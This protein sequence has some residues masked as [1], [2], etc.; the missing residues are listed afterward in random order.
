MG[1]GAIL[2]IAMLS[3]GAFQQVT[4]WHDGI[5]LMLHTLQCTRN[6]AF[7]H[8]SLG[9]AYL[10][11]G[12]LDEAQVQFQQVL[13]LHPEHADAEY[14]L[15]CLLGQK[16]L[17]DG[18]I[19]HYQR[20]LLI[21]PDMATVHNNL[22]ELLIKMGRFDEA[23]QH[24]G[25]ALA[26]VP[27]MPEAETNLLTLLTA[28]GRLKEADLYFREALSQN[29]T[30]GETH[31]SMAMILIQEGDFR[32]AI[33][34]LA[35]AVALQPFNANHANNLAWTLA[36][37]PDPSLRDARRSVELSKRAVHLE[38]RNPA[39]LRTLAAAYAASGEFSLA[40]ETAREAERLAVLQGNTAMVQNI[41]R[42]L[43]LYLAGKAIGDG[44]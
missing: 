7:A 29:P 5:D 10:A 35:Q 32:Q 38:P 33:A 42:E 2:V 18:A 23:R 44:R 9:E 3:L 25:R 40:I 20:A 37:L 24:L 41:Q 39:I 8:F 27:R 19:V 11:D 21:N 12:R 1:I 15:G 22:A 43:A 6:N 16:G 36:T 13:A 17:L 28:Q 14:D 30:S 4:Y 31:G 26:I 34:E